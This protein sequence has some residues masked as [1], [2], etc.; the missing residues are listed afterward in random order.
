MRCRQLPRHPWAERAVGSGPSK[1]ARGLLGAGQ[2]CQ[3]AEAALSRSVAEMQVK[4][5]G[6]RCGCWAGSRTELPSGL[7]PPDA[8]RFPVPSRPHVLV[9]NWSCFCIFC[10]KV[11]Y[12]GEEQDQEQERSLFLGD[13]GHQSPWW[14]RDL[15]VSLPPLHEMDA[16]RRGWTW[17]E[18]VLYVYVSEEMGW[19]C[20][21]TPAPHCRSAC[22]Q[23]LRCDGGAPAGS[24]PGWAAGS[25]PRAEAQGILWVGASA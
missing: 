24:E 4:G 14:P 11:E 1:D 10:V 17:N 25:L 5:R 12:R 2:Q 19:F 6:P 3:D 20:W 7:L 22:D 8:V 16:P 18:L 23:T 13:A 15:A 21:R 9:S